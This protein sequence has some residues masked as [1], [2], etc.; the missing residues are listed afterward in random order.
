MKNVETKNELL[1][2]VA[3]P[4]PVFNGRF[5]ARVGSARQLSLLFIRDEKISRWAIDRSVVEGLAAAWRS[6]HGGISASRLL[7][8]KLYVLREQTNDQFPKRLGAWF[9]A[10]A[11]VT[12]WRGRVTAGGDWRCLRG[13]FSE[14]S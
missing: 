8:R 3:A 7:N 1:F 10:S 14:V 11:I 12:I 2:N 9:A 13:K 4:P 5:Y 6:Y